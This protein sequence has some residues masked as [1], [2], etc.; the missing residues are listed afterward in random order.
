MTQTNEDKIKTNT[1]ISDLF[2]QKVSHRG[3]ADTLNVQGLVTPTG[4]KWTACNIYAH[5]RRVFN[6]GKALTKAKYS[7]NKTAIA[8]TVK[9]TGPNFS[10]IRAV[11]FDTSLSMNKKLS[12]ITAYIE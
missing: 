8:Q 5:Y 2:T 10:F 12:I 11:L 6:G 3:I 9:A 1:M 7:K 4:K